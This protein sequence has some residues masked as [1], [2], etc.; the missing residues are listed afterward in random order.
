M[1]SGL[2]E[3]RRFFK[4][5]TDFEADCVSD[6][7]DSIR[8]APIAAVDRCA[9]LKA[10][11]GFFVERIVSS[12]CEFGI[13]RHWLCYTVKRKITYDFGFSARSGDAG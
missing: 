6:Q 1:S 2:G 11:G 9:C 3:S 4:G 13:E 12:A 10:D 7:G 5:N 8:H